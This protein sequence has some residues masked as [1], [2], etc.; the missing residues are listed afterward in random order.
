MDNLEVFS[1]QGINASCK[2]HSKFVLL[3]SAAILLSNETLMDAIKSSFG[4][5]LLFK[6]LEQHQLMQNLA[7]SAWQLVIA[8]KISKYSFRKRFC[9][10]S[11]DK[12]LEGLSLERS[13]GGK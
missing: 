2:F 8:R 3:F 1:Y 9:Q 13:F 4:Q 7:I 12:E 10:K 5:K 11:V 6:I